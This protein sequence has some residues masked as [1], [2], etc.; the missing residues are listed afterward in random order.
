M[1]GIG[2]LKTNTELKKLLSMHF[3]EQGLLF[4]LY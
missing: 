3:E 2:R 4:S 1:T